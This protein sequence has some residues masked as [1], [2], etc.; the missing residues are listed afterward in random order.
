MNTDQLPAPP[1]D[2]AEL[3]PP[4]EGEGIHTYRAISFIGANFAPGNL[5]LGVCIEKGDDDGLRYQ[6]WFVTWFP[7]PFL[8]L[9]WCIAYRGEVKPN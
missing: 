8:R 3:F 9:Q 1:R 2:K 5:C 4:D 6:D 7:L